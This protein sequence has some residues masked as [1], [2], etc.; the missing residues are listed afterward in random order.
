MMT[1]RS[2]V[3]H[4][5]VGCLPQVGQVFFERTLKATGQVTRRFCSLKQVS[6]NLLVISWSWSCPVETCFNEQRAGKIQIF[7]L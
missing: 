1:S 7:S 5:I 2:E 4:D 6:Q 3:L